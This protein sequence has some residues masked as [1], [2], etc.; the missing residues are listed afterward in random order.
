M[1]LSLTSFPPER[2]RYDYRI[3]IN[4]RPLRNPV[5]AYCFC[6]HDRT[7]CGRRRSWICCSYCMAAL[8]ACGS[9]VQFSCDEVTN[10]PCVW[11]AENEEARKRPIDVCSVKWKTWQALLGHIAGQLLW[12]FWESLRVNPRWP[13]WCHPS[14]V[15]FF[16]IA[17]V[18][19][20]IE[21]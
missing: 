15:V 11:Q 18:P 1:R 7:P 16:V 9:P 8:K 17:P 19:F 21:N 13:S 6:K 5:G 3:P 2:S 4:N 20:A 14:D 12:H 10:C